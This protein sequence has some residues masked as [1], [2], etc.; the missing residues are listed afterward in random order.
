MNPIAGPVFPIPTA[1]YP[2][3]EVDYD[4]TRSYVDFLLKSGAKNI[5]VTVGT[6]RFNLLETEEM[7]EVNRII[8]QTVKEKDGNVIL[9]NGLTGS[10]KTSLKFAELAKK[11]HADAL[12]VYYPERYYSDTHILDFYRALGEVGVPLMIHEMPMRAGPNTL[13][14]P[15]Q[16]SLSLLDKLLELPYVI[17]MKEESGNINHSIEILKKHANQHAIILAG[18]AKKMLMS[19]LPFGANTYLVG[20]GSLAPKLALRFWEEIR[21]EN[22]EKAFEIERDYEAPFFAEAFKN[23]WHLSMK[24]GMSYLGLMPH[25]ERAPLQPMEETAAKSLQKT[26]DSLKLRALL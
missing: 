3:G 26:I 4:A 25:Y 19:L 23:G 15:V 21:S 9:T 13:P 17:G 6:S 24:E 5:L 11:N 14:N 18:A 16:Y 8:A 7:L 22:W 12:M 2:N 1:F 10:L 20:V